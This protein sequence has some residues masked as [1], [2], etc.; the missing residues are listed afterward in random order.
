[1]K[2]KWVRHMLAIIL[3][4]PT[5]RERKARV[6]AAQAAARQAERKKDDAQHVRHD[7]EKILRQNHFAQV[8]VDG[9]IGDDG[10][11]RG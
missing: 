5:R 2:W 8:I 4:W 7:L 1:M 9:L 6:A 11:R 10:G 3:P